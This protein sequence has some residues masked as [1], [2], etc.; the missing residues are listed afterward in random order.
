MNS[1]TGMGRL[2]ADPELKYSRDASI[3]ITRFTIAIDTGFGDKKRTDF[4]RCVA[5]G[6]TAES[7]SEYLAK[8]KRVLFNG[9]LKI[10]SYTN[11]DGVKI[12]TA[13]IQ[14]SHLEFIDYIEKTTTENKN[15]NDNVADWFTD[16]D[17][18]EDIPF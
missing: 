2:T 8:G 10:D 16:I 18:S 7:A 3:A 12:P 9:T 13:E 14:I 17:D 1:F 4:I 5:F 15:T 6:K 11:K